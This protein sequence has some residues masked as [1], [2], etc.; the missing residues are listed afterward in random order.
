MLKMAWRNVWRNHRRSSI[1]IAAMTL[2]LFVELLYAG[3]VAGLVHG[4]SDD[5]T[6]YELG[7][8]QIF[9]DGYLTRP[10]LYEAVDDHE[11]LMQ[12]LEDAGYRTT[13]RLFAGGLSASGD[14][15]AGAQFVGI[16]PVRDA[17]AMD[18][19]LAIGEGE[20]LDAS[21]PKGVVVGRG[22]A[23]IL[24]L[25]LG[26]EVLVLS[27]ATDGSIANDLF[28]VRGILLSVAA[29]MDRS[30]ILMV[31]PTFREL[32]VFDEGA[33]KVFVRTPR[34]QGLLEARDAIEAIVAAQV[35][36]EDVRV[37]TWKEV[38]PMLAQYLDSAESIIVVVYF[39]VYLAV[40]ILILN[41]M[42]MAVFERIR[43]FGVLK[44]I[45]YGPGQVLFMM[46]AEAMIQACVATVL[47]I[48]LAAPFMYWLQVYGINVGTL[49]GMQMAGM[50]MP[51]IWNGYYTLATTRVPVLMLFFIVFAAVIYPALKAAWIRPVEAMH[52]Q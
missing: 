46:V 48:L 34:D 52:H 32:M 33:H 23:R 35:G 3:L 14:L 4:M 49:G 38:N 10:S 12:A 9:A 42:L 41:A 37:K 29:G 15:S 44:A 28:Q 45:G 50:T 31:E 1:T 19:H 22:L 27:Q 39:I 26:D 17:R 16:D 21:D 25:D 7:E 36:L 2:A 30:G 13:A 20:W 40:G 47:G 43:E 51:P 11:P 8:V 5:A 24:D 6:A 18:L